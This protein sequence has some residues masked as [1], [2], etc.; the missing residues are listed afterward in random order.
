MKAIVLGPGESRALGELA[1]KYDV[2]T[3]AAEH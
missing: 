1:A 3:V 2:Q